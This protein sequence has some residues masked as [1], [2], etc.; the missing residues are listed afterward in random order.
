MDRATSDRDRLKDVHQ[1]DLTEGRIN[2]D[3]VDWLKTKGTSWLLVA[4][5]ALF[6][7]AA[8]VRWKHHRYSYQ[9]EAWTE[10]SSASLPNSL[11][12]IAEKYKDV[13]AVPHLARLHAAS[14][15]LVAVQ[16]GKT[17][18]ATETDQTPLT[19]EAREDY[20][21]R[22][23]QLYKKIVEADDQQQS[24]ALLVS[25]ALNGRAAIAESRGNFDEAR[26][27]YEQ[28]AARVETL[29]PELAAHARAQAYG[30]EESNREVTLPTRAEIMALQTITPSQ[31]DPVWTEPWLNDVLNSK[32]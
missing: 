1:T 5:V 21:N 8:I 9:S 17:L 31:L 20:L 13:G 24:M 7:Y 27:H 28:A 32:P 11:E 10:L 19:P 4:M 23:D 25:T 3:F 18:G 30:V 14:Q 26:G 29:F 6:V 15:L 2:Q 12:D 16:T 22:A